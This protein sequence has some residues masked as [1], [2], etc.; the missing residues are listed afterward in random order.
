MNENRGVWL[1][2]G[3][4]MISLAAGGWATAALAS[5]KSSEYHLANS[6]L[7]I[8]GGLGVVI[9]VSVVILVLKANWLKRNLLRY[10]VKYAVLQMKSYQVSPGDDALG[11]EILDEVNELSD[12][13]R[14]YLGRK[15]FNALVHFSIDS[16][17][18]EATFLE[19]TFPIGRA[20]TEIK[21]RLKRLAEMTT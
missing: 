2:V 1:A 16:E 21:I 8:I 4:A 11:Q 20:R 5:K 9:L 14:Q 10:K 18:S 13:V 3:L 15:S 7:G 12:E 6:V 17:L 19:G